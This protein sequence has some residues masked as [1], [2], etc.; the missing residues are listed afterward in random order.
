ML[1]EE[2]TGRTFSSPLDKEA[3]SG[4]VIRA[5][6]HL[7][8]FDSEHEFD[9]GTGCSSFTQPIAGHM[10][11]ARLRA[12]DPAH[13]LSL[14]PLWGHRGDASRLCRWNCA[15][16]QRLAELRGGKGQARNPRTVRFSA[17]QLKVLD[18][19]QL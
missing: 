18:I 7:P 1:L 11:T 4:S 8:L 15:R 17:T 13:R 19:T 5:A 16:D 10:G 6:C 9:S 12:A 3:R 2:G 14:R